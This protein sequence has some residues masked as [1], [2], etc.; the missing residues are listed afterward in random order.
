MNKKMS[1]K[2]VFQPLTEHEKIGDL[3][4]GERKNFK[5]SSGGG[6]VRREATD[7]PEEAVLLQDYATSMEEANFSEQVG[8]A[9]MREATRIYDELKISGFDF[10][11]ID[12]S[13]LQLEDLKNIEDP[14]ERITIALDRLEAFD[15]QRVLT[16]MQEVSGLKEKILSSKIIGAALLLA[17]IAIGAI[18]FDTVDK[19]LDI[20]NNK[21]KQQQYTIATLSGIPSDELHDNGENIEWR[22]KNQ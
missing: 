1:K 2:E 15:D 13:K 21:I 4:Q 17:A 6:Y 8:R 9:S 16:L 19:R 7:T 5:E 12:F 3:P 22:A 14:K 20:M 10:S 18:T 11:S